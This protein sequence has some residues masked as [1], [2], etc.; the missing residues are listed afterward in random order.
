M[1]TKLDHLKALAY[2]C[3]D[4]GGRLAI[5]AQREFDRV[6]DTEKSTWKDE[7]Q[8]AS[9]FTDAHGLWWSRKV[10]YAI[11]GRERIDAIIHEMGHVFASPH[12]PHHECRECHE[13]NW[14][15][16]EIALARQIGAARAWSRGSASYQTGEYGY[17]A[18]SKLTPKQRRGVVADRLAHACKIGILGTAGDLRSVR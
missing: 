2:V 4:F 15:G 13:W 3:K 10:V 12:P 18:W 8:S 11:E 16:W 17:T 5:V 7:E 1:P 6:F 9:P 14:F